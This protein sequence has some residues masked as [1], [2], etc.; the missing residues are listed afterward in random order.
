MAIELLGY[1]GFAFLDKCE[2]GRMGEQLK[3]PPASIQVQATQNEDSVVVNSQ[4]A[5]AP[6]SAPSAES[7]IIVNAI[8]ERGSVVGRIP[9]ERIFTPFEITTY[10]A[11]DIG[12]LVRN[13]GP[14][15]T[16]I[17][18]GEEAVPIVLLNGRRV[19]SFSDIA[20]IPTEAIERMEVFPEEL[21]LAYGFR[22]DQKV[23]NIV[24]FEHFSSQNADVTSIIPTEGGRTNA[25][26]SSNLLR[27]RNDTRFNF[28]VSY[29]EAGTLLESEREL[30]PLDANVGPGEF[31]TILPQINRFSVNGSV[32]R[33]ISDAFSATLN[34]R[35]TTETNTFVLGLLDT[36][37]VQRNINSDTFQ[38]G[39]VLDGRR[40]KWTWTLA[41][42]YLS[43]TTGITT[44]L[45]QPLSSAGSEPSDR[46]ASS[47]NSASAD[48]VLGGPLVSLPA[49]TANVSLRASFRTLDF[50]RTTGTNLAGNESKL[51]RDSIAVQAS[52]DMPIINSRTGPSWAG[53][54]SANVIL[55]V[56]ELSDVPKLRTY[57]VGLNWS[58]VE[59]ISIYGSFNAAER[60]PS[61]DQLGA[62]E[63][64]TPNFRIF[65]FAQAETIDVLQRFGG[66]LSLSS[67][68]R[69]E[70]RVGFQGRPFPD[71]DLN[72][73][74]NY[75]DA[76][77][78][79][80]VQD[81]TVGNNDIES[82]LPD[83]FVRNDDG[84][85]LALDARP[86]N[87]ARA[88]QQTLRSGVT[89]NRQLSEGPPPPPGTIGTKV[90]VFPNEEAM[91]AALP[92]GTVIVE[93]LPGSVQEQEIESL[94]SRIT[95]ALFHT[96]SLRDEITPQSGGP[97]FDRLNGFA[98]DIRELEPRHQ[99]NFQ[100][101]L[102]RDWYGARLTADWLSGSQVRGMASTA[103]G[104][105]RELS[106]S[107]LTT[108]DLSVFAN[109]AESLGG[110]NA[111]GWLKGI[112]IALSIDNIFNARRKAADEGGAT[113]VL[114]Q[115]VNFDPLGR[116]FTV[117]LRK[118][119]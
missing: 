117:S 26:V 20:R 110:K 37:P 113:P 32:A 2:N 48:L 109:I 62:P 118:I 56:E 58:P 18:S 17:R 60:A 64:V 30:R 90:Q 71:T 106:V 59:A 49:G 42:N 95:I 67:E 35:F 44:G 15:A 57:G 88:R 105:N 63:I 24:T 111:A 81:F 107:D 25:Q 19:P 99:I 108:I 38:A 89:Y 82:V 100:A 43:A 54:L 28:D 27:I 93:A 101:G 94:S 22:P 98:T 115:P 14:I 41:A 23:I 96:W 119:F 55:A 8:P 78:D 65:D 3:F 45:G 104:A 66:N 68:D 92:P 112:R 6:D 51:G 53:T 74:V 40:N 70:F 33:T 91:R 52:I 1:L 9:P 16:S 97:S 12:S 61:I 13:L 114:F 10:D 29:T 116:S 36:M 77:I 21:A 34:S 75:V 86:L 72:F 5:D 103:L 39:L 85:L 79:S 84:R 73:S 4:E 80:P 83:R 7:E 11:T 46:I 69:Q 102:F 87:F 76:E 50:T 31:R 47:S